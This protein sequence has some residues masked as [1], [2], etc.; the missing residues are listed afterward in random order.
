MYDGLDCKDGMT[1][2]GMARDAYNN[3]DWDTMEKLIGYN[4]ADCYTVN[5]IIEYMRAQ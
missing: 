2:M 5:N 3:N 1:S 4:K